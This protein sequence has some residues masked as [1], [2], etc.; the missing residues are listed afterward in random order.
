MPVTDFGEA[1]AP[2]PARGGG[3]YRAG[4]VARERQREAEAHE[5]RDDGEGGRRMSMMLP[6]QAECRCC[7]AV[8][9]A[10]DVYRHYFTSYYIAD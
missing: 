1:I 3:I 10:R 9:Y 5:A 2:T 7:F 4:A 6:S 8:I